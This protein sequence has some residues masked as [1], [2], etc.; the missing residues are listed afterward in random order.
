[1]KTSTTLVT[2]ATPAVE[3][4]GFV[5]RAAAFLLDII[6]VTLGSIVFAALASLI[7]NFFGFNASSMKTDDPA[8]LLGF[9]QII[10]VAFTGFAVLLFI[11]AY[12]VIFWVL[13]GATP[14]KQILGLQV[15]RTNKQSIGWVRATIR[16]FAYFLSAIVFFLGY[17]WVFIDGRRQGW[18]D[19]IADTFVVYSWDTK[20]FKESEAGKVSP[21]ASN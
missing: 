15:I 9:I 2:P 18:H 17:L 14:G 12:F 4:A 5:S 10:I 8:S 13:V 1:M 20:K 3:Q 7:L 11:P 21:K 19:K 16:Y 6:F